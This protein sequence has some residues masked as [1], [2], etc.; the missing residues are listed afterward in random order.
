MWG[1]SQEQAFEQ[2]KTELSQPTVLALYDPKAPTKVSADASSYGL[3]AV[4]LQQI[5]EKWKPVAYASRSMTDTEKRYA[6]IEKESL[7]VTWS[8]EKFSCYILGRHFNID[9]PLVPLLSTKNLD[10]LP[11]RILR[12]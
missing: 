9:K 11:P 4:L 5:E 3:G 7:A 2:I 8:C 12:F 10:N 6:Q 1:S